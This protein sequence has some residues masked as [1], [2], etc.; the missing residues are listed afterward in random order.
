MA[1]AASSEGSSSQNT[2]V[3]TPTFLD[4][5]ISRS[6]SQSSVRDFPWPSLFM[7][8]P[9]KRKKTKGK[10]WADLFVYH[11]KPLYLINNKSTRINKQYKHLIKNRTFV[12]FVNFVLTFL[13]IS[14]TLTNVIFREGIS[15][16]ARRIIGGVNARIDPDLNVM[17]SINT[18]FA[19]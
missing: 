5:S 9:G 3:S 10:K 17:R 13:S 1:A 19:F 7:P 4:R 2:P 11:F 16:F 6:S 12:I 14:V 8:K 15:W 18:N